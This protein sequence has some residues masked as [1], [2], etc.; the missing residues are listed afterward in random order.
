MIYLDWASTSPPDAA[1]LAQAAESAS[2]RFGNP[3]SAHALGREARAE[4]AACRSRFASCLGAP[5]GQ[6]V[7]TGGGSEAD[8][9]AMLSALR[10]QD[11]LRASGLSKKLRIVTTEIEHP[12][13]FEEAKLL[14]SL[15]MDLVFLRPGPDGLVAPGEVAEAI[16]RET[17]LVAVMAVNNETGAIQDLAGISAAIAAASKT[18][19]TKPPRLHADAVQ[20]LGKIEFNPARLGI[21]SAAFSAH[22][23]RGPRCFGALWTAFPFEPLALGGGQ[24]G[25]MRAGTE[26]LQGA[27]AFAAAAEKARAAL[28]EGRAAALALESRLLDGLAKI[29]GASALPL[30]RRPGD[31]RYS[32]FIL[33]AAFPGLSG[34]VFA[35]ALSD[36]GL[37]VSTGSACSTNSRRK[38]RRVLEAMGLEPELAFS[39]IRLSWGGLSSPQDIDAFLEAASK[40]YLRLKT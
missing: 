19:G 27:W 1:I 25:G 29:P 3:S 38:G 14:E 10:A 32:P 26:S 15:G 2:T 40:L 28:D 31:P 7:F 21:S 16:T 33:S 20:A 37:A 18:L 30:G 23:I 34:E 4:L 6:V 17:A 39:S 22:K 24:E 12:A 13:I 36:E 9:I 11:R 35:R 8:A 5:S